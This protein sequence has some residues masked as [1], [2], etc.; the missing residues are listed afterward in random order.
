LRKYEKI[1]DI[2]IQIGVILGVEL[3]WH[4]FCEQK[5]QSGWVGEWRLSIA[6]CLR[7]GSFSSKL[8]WK[9]SGV[10]AGFI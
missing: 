8:P 6:I 2:S 9:K 5:L 7:L 4:T 10:P 1:H 3:L